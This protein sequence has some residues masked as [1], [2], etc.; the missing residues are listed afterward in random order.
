MRY[1][2]TTVYRG[3]CLWK[4]VRLVQKKECENLLL[5]ALTVSL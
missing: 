5:S 4:H 2:G 3:W 1:L